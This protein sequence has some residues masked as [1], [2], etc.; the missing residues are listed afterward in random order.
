M[1]VVAMPRESEKPNARHSSWASCIGD[2]SSSQL[3]A[4]DLSNGVEVCE[5]MEPRKAINHAEYDHRSDRGPAHATRREN[6]K[7]QV[8]TDKLERGRDS[9]LASS[10][11]KQMTAA[12]LEFQAS[13]SALN[14]KIEEL[15]RGARLDNYPLPTLCK[16]EH[17]RQ[18]ADAR[19]LR[20]HRRESRDPY[21]MVEERLKRQHSSE[22]FREQLHSEIPM[23]MVNFG[24]ERV[25]MVDVGLLRNRCQMNSRDSVRSTLQQNR[26]LTEQNRLVVAANSTFRTSS[27]MPM[28]S[29]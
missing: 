6:L 9:G 19:R 20:R 2:E 25:S 4:V 8:L 18:R 28:L 13:A 3:W 10:G 14:Q 16:N 1:N 12:T 7:A 21:R 23:Q 5:P 22:S 27:S 24:G 15:T 11:H 29:R 26:R 17:L